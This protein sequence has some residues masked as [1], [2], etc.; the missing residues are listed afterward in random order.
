M[1]GYLDS[2]PHPWTH[3]HIQSA[4]TSDFR[5]VQ[6][7]I[8]QTQGGQLWRGMKELDDALWVFTRSTDEVLGQ[9][10]IF[11]E[12]SKYPQFWHKNLREEFGNIYS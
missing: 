7:S 11:G 8:E 3:Q 9:I 5:T 4:I 6:K 12:K 10:N 1:A 2:I